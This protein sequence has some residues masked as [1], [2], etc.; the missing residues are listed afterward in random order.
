[1]KPVLS[2]RQA[3]SLVICGV[4]PARMQSQ[5]LPGKPLL[6]ICAR[7]MI[8]WVYERSCTS[9]LLNRLVVATDS[10]QILRYCADHGI[11]ALSTSRQHL[12]GTDRLIEVMQRES[13]NGRAADLYVNIQGDEP[14][15]TAH[16]IDLLVRP[17]VRPGSIA[18]PVERPP[19]P[20]GSSYASPSPGSEMAQVSTLRVAITE[21]AATD[22]DNVKVVTDSRGWA[23]YFSRAAIPHHRE[24]SG[25]VRYYKHLG[26]YAYTPAAL[27]QF[28]SLAPSPL[29]QSEGLEQLRFLENGIPIAVLETGADTIGVDTEDDL[30]RVER[31]FQQAGM[32]A[33]P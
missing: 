23:L 8:H 13:A 22:P 24:N 21:E 10:D 5:R 7:P 3:R 31:Y 11:P 19:D 33:T 18:D 16:H 32:G 14:M 6:P 15:V 17:F 29:E 2:L 25:R 1:M 27:R 4:I 26:F 30:R 9:T 12:S 28:H 20:S